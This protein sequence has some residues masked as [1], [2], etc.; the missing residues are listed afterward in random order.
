MTTEE[1]IKDNYDGLFLDLFELFHFRIDA[2]IMEFNSLLA[3]A[4]VHRKMM[5]DLLEIKGA[6]A[7]RTCDWEDVYARIMAILTDIS[8]GADFELTVNGVGLKKANITK[9]LLNIQTIVMSLIQEQE[10]K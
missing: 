2:L 10:L 8:V 3:T 9:Q 5:A 1:E 4:G 6:T 7:L